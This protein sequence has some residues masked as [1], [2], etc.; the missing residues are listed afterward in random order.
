M[1]RLTLDD[2]DW[3]AGLITVRGKGPRVAHMPL[4][5]DVGTAMA[6]Y[7][8]HAR[9]NCASRRVFIRERA[10]VGGFRQLDRD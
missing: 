1:V 2:L 6:D 4:P 5:V 9:P 10:P 8:R 3:D 7:L